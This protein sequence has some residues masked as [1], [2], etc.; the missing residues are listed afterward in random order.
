[1]L[2]PLLAASVRT[3]YYLR[4]YMPTN[5]ALEAIRTRRGLKWDVPAMLLAVPYLLA[6]SICISLIAEGGAGWLSCS[7]SWLE[8]AFVRLSGG[9]PV[10]AKARTR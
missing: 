6:A 1:M 2:R 8:S 5:I 10:S 3:R 4:H 7:C 9:A